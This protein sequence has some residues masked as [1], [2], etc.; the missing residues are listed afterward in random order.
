MIQMDRLGES[1]HQ[2]KQE[3]KEMGYKQNATVGIHSSATFNTYKSS[4]K[5]FV[6]WAK[7]TGQNIKNIEDVKEEHIRDYIKYREEQGCS[8]HTYSKD[9]SALN[10]VFGTDVLKS[11]CGVANRSYKNITNNREMKEH[12]KHI[13][14][15]NYKSEITVARATGMRRES[16]EKVSPNSFNYDDKGYPVSVRLCDERSSGGVNM[17][18]KGG[19]ERVAEVLQSER[20]ELKAVIE[21][22]L[23]E[24]GGDRSKP[25][26][27]HIPTRLGTHR[28]R[29]EYAK[30]TYNQYLREHGVGTMKLSD[31]HEKKYEN[32]R[33][34]DLRGYDVAALK[35]TT[36]QLGHN[37]LDVAVY[38]YLGANK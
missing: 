7:D 10:K 18:E 27:D 14:Y 4:C 24:N 15:N 29:Q 23:E 12:H 31:T 17:K 8:G 19:R 26:F 13:N 25:L 1:R 11:D 3:A 32:D 28:F 9:L 35:H 30:E 20:E 22:K 34:T 2:A 33:R 36:E 6:K 16:L 21:R 5:Q 38:N 37:R